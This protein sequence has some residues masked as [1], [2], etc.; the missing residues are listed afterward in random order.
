MATE[1]PLEE[2]IKR[3][4][5][6]FALVGLLAPLTALIPPR[7]EDWT[8][9]W[10][11]TAL[12][13]VIAATGI[14]VPWSRLAR[15]TYIV[16]PLAYFV[17][18]ALLREASDGSVSGYAPLAL[19]PVVWIALNLGRREVAIG[20]GVGTSV[21]V[22]PLIVGDPESYTTS[23]WQR[24]VLWAAVAA[25][26][27]F[28]VESIMREQAGAHAPGARARADD[29]RDRKCHACTDGRDRCANAHL[30]CDARARRGKLRRDL[31]ARRPG[32]AGHHGSGGR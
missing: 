22:L 14:L 5:I 17:V 20:I 23:D 11:A 30:Q 27:G 26:V 13:F 9:V 24:A 1:R 28:S 19:L 29:G 31:G 6:P 25:I 8:Y 18:V 10:L 32:R 21:F 16:P 4:F 3:R 2:N 12:T 7:P 15:W